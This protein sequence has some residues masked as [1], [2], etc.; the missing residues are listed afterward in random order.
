MLA[1]SLSENFVRYGQ[2]VMVDNS[3]TIELISKKPLPFKFEPQIL[4]NPEFPQLFEQLISSIRATLPVP[5]RFI[6]FSAC[7]SWFNITNNKVDFGLDD[8]QVQ[9]VLDWNEKQRLGENFEKKFVQH[10]PLKVDESAAQRNFLTLSYYKELGRIIHKT[11]QPVGFTVKVFDIN[12]F[13]AAN[14]LE[15]LQGQKTGQKWGVWRIGENSN[16]LLIVENGEFKQY[17]EFDLPD[18]TNYAINVMSNPEGEGEKVV[19]QINDLRTFKSDQINALDNL[20][21]FSH[22]PDSEFFNMLLTYDLDNMHVLDPF[23]D[24]KPI[25]LYTGDGD[26]PGA[27]CQFLDVMGLLLRFMPEAHH[28]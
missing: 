26:G 19:A 24:I 8:E 16:I 28:D 20:Y 9:Q 7:S 15:R 3:T 2:L 5:D 21:F 12:I 18:A 27:M 17:L 23:A 1:V 25:D 11:C 4:L 22:D 13:A 6:A 14:A 10:Y